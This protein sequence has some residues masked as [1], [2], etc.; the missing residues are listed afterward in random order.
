MKRFGIFA[1]L[2]IVTAL[3]AFS[4]APS[5]GESPMNPDEQALMEV[6]ENV[7]SLQR[8]LSEAQIRGDDAEKTKKLQ[9]EFD[10][11]Q[12]KRVELLRKTWQM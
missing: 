8:Q 9:K 1:P 4:P 3:L 10:A 2:L 6:E 7:L 11:L 12:K 5:S